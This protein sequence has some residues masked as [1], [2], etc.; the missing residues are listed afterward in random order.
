[1]IVKSRNGDRVT[2]EASVGELRLLNNALNEVC[3]GVDIPDAAFA[4]RV[5]GSRADAEA[6]LKVVAGALEGGGAAPA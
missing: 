6:L 2:L 1:M 4:T 3:N 5:G